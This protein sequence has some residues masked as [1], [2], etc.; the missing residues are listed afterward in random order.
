MLEL[1]MTVLSKPSKIAHKIHT[2]DVV[3]FHALRHYKK[4]ITNARC[5]FKMRIQ[6]KYSY[7]LVA[8][9]QNLYEI[10]RCVLDREQS[11]VL[12]DY[13]FK[14]HYPRKQE[15]KWLCDHYEWLF[16]NMD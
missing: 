2:Q 6:K 4:D 3:I 1:T 7:E 5:F 13:F 10:M 14:G 9:H 12:A 11:Q 8:L 15:L 16:K